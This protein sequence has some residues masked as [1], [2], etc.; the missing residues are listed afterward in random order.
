[1]NRQKIVMSVISRK[2]S[3]TIEYIIIIA[4]AVI[5]AGLL[6]FIFQGNG[7]IQANLEKKVNL[8]LMGEVSEPSGSSNSNKD[9]QGSVID[10]PPW[11]KKSLDYG[12]NLLATKE[13]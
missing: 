11:F 10:Q 6:Y 12:S 7:S 3:S 2:G 4:T 8:A 5:F 1:M 9:P 13:L